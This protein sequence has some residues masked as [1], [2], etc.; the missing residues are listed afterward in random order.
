MEHK[1]FFPKDWRQYAMSDSKS[2]VN[3]CLFSFLLS[4]LEVARYRS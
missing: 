1:E 4:R 2:S 3:L